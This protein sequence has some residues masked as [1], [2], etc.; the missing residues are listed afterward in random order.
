M[1]LIWL[2]CEVT[3][4]SK[5]PIWY[6]LFALVGSIGVL[7]KESMP[8]PFALCALWIF[9]IL[10]KRR[11]WTNL[12]ILIGATAAGMGASVWWLSHQVGSLADFLG[13]VMRIPRENAANPY[14][15]EYASGPAYL[16]LLA[17]WIIAPV[18][19]LLSLAGL[20]AA[21]KE[22][23]MP[24]TFLA[25]FTVAYV[26]IAMAEPHFLNLR[27]VGNTYGS[28]CLL[29]GLGCWYLISSG[30]A[31]MDVSDRRP[32]AVVAIAIVLGGTMADYLRFRRY[33]VRDE[34]AD[35]S[36]KMLMDER[37]Q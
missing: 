33:F 22:R 26:A 28:L 13:I 5:K 19:S 31:W 14:A 15:L 18:T 7:I 37:G 1:L 29:A 20:F 3:R 10:L 9:W 36:I 16:M 6:L 30:L 32:F 25:G 8:V 21:W 27:Y 24:L 17:F 34:T 12:W 35:L 11:E 23:E 4:D 2:A